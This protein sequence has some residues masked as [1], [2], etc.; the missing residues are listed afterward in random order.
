MF[1]FRDETYLYFLIVIPLCLLVC[2]L[3]TWIG[4]R[5][6]RQLGGRPTLLRLMPQR[7]LVR[8]WVKCIL[9]CLALGLLAVCLARPQYGMTERQQTTQG[10]EAVVMVDVSNSMWADDVQPNRLERAKLLLNNLVD[11]MENDKI[12]VGVFAGEAYPQLPITSDYA[13]AKLCIDALSP[14]MV[15]LQGTNIGAA[16]DLACKSF[17]DAQGVGRAV[18]LITDG[19]NHE[20]GALEAVQR[21]AKQGVQ[22]YVMGIGTAAGGRIPMPG[23]G[24]LTD[25]QGAP[26]LTSLNEDM[27]RRLAQAGKGLYLHIDQ[28]N[29]AQTEL[30]SQLS[31]LKQGSTTLSYTEHD[32]QFQ[33][34]A[35]LV[36]L[37]LIIEVCLSESSR[38]WLQRI[39][40]FRK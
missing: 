8:Q 39:K 12:A 15:T 5:K 24:V 22:V 14:E 28:S 35:L 26:V 17:T 2:F 21:A 7:S 20:D 9:L 40:F 33:A 10:I 36:L 25:N 29:S 6:L 13:A 16:V 27:C 38:T 31:R 19:E 34:V 32:E 11:K 4:K 30:L 1:Q 3:S 18:I 37:L 23:G